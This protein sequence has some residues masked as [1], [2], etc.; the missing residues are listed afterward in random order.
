MPIYN[1][2]VRISSIRGLCIPDNTF[3]LTGFRKREKCDF[4]YLCCRFFFVI[5]PF[6]SVSIPFFFVLSQQYNANWIEHRC[7]MSR[8]FF[9]SNMMMWWC[10]YKGKIITA[11][12]IRLNEQALQ[13]HG[14]RMQNI[15]NC[16][17]KSKRQQNEREKSTDVRF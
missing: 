6:S 16:A 1:F 7:G 13:T 9:W 2:A 12:Q 14:R 4:C 15:V 17:Q 11:N 10:S 8:S 3:N 5:R